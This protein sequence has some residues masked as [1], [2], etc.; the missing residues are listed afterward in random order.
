MPISAMPIGAWSKSSSNRFA[1]AWPRSKALPQLPLEAVGC[2]V[3][4][5]CKPVQVFHGLRRRE[6]RGS[7]RQ[8]DG[9][10]DDVLLELLAC[11]SEQLRPPGRVS[12]ALVE[13]A[14]V[15][16]RGLDPF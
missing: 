4:G 2:Q 9:P 1:L 7:S 8:L 10:A 6:Q 5:F 13:V 15:I 11:G 12:R 14:K 3:Q 16:G